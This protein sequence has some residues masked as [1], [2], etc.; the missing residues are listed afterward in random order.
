MNLR[1]PSLKMKLLASFAFVAIL[2][3]GVGAVGVAKLSELD[4]ADTRLY[5]KMTVPLADLGEAGVAFQRSRVNFLEFR[6]AAD[7]EAKKDLRSRI[8]ARREDVLKNLKNFEGTIMTDAG[9]ATFNGMLADVKQYFKLQDDMLALEDAGKEAEANAIFA[10][11]GA[12]SRKKVQ[13]QLDSLFAQKVKIAKETSEEN[14]RSSNAA[15]TLMTSAVIVGV[16]GA[17][18]LGF[19]L[20][21]SVSKALSRVVETL[22]D[23]SNQISSAS[24]ELSASSQS[25]AE[26]ATEQAASLEETSSAME[27]I[28]AMTQQNAGNA[29]T[30]RKLAA[31]A[32]DAAR[33]ANESMAHVVANMDD[34]SQVGEEIG[35]IVKTIDD[36]AFQTNL[37]ALNAAVEAARA[38]EAG[39][40]FGV[41]ADEVRNLA[42]RAASSAQNTTN[43]IEGVIRKIT[44]G[45]ELVRKTDAVFREVDSSVAK[46]NDLMA[47]IAT[48]STEQSRGIQ[49]ISSSIQQMDQVT[50]HSA[51]ASEQVASAAVE[52][53]SQAGSLGEVVWLL[54]NIVNG[55]QGTMHA[56]ESPN[57]VEAPR[58]NETRRPTQGRGRHLNG[59]GRHA[60]A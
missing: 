24:T 41:V 60:H 34:I 30:A 26:G 27:Q 7:A 51:A 48:A 52:L 19:F 25:L 3:A 56:S 2:L 23:G 33:K 35:K 46:V 45:T 44:T 53:S 54:E 11:E 31:Q 36:I 37:L 38:G 9:R 58:H 28:S 14:A 29:E 55:E 6:S 42:Q 22:T 39:A 47:E 5:E 59:H 16:I 50:Q 13:E 21:R 10:G 49:E 17:M 57:E 1:H 43:L 40:G 12:V 8:E 4:E 32:G 18:L 20:S 15:Q